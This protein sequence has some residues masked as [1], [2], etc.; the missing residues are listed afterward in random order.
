MSY[1]DKITFEESTLLEGEQAEEYKAR[2]AK[3]ASDKAKAAEN[4]YQRRYGEREN[5]TT[6][7]NNDMKPNTQYSSYTTGTVNNLKVKDSK[8]L[9][10]DQKQ[11]H[12]N[13]MESN[14]KKAHI[15]ATKE[16]NKREFNRFWNSGSNNDAMKKKSNLSSA[17][18][19]ISRHNRRHPNAKVESV[20]ELAESLLESY[21]PD[22]I[23]C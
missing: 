18:D 11:K 14:D 3:E 4:K 16:A 2:K 7:G 20:I 8:K 13:K 10:A 19:A 21:Q 5:T 15:A 1:L 12:F 22:C 9:S 17:A 23:F 6:L